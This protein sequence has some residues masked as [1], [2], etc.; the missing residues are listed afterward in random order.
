MSQDAI[1]DLQIRVE[2][3][4]M[5]IEQLNDTVAMQARLLDELRDE[6]T[7]LRERLQALN[8]SPLGD[9]DHDEPP[10]HY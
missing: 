8:P 2:H 5:A 1:E 6:L 10:P 4:E 3:Q 9:A 7:R